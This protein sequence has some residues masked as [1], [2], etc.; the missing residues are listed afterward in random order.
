MKHARLIS[1][2]YKNAWNEEAMDN[3]VDAAGEVNWRAA[4]MA[5]PGVKKCPKCG[6][7]YWDEASVMECTECQT[8]FG[9][10]LQHPTVGGSHAG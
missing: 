4:F 7:F 9:S 10:G 5:D 3:V 1:G 8:Q 6:E 2:E